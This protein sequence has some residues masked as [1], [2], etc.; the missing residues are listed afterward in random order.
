M[1]VVIFE[2]FSVLSFKVM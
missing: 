2:G 1:N